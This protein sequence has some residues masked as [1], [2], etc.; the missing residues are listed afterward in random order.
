MA[1]LA[2]SLPFENMAASNDKRE[3]GRDGRRKKASREAPPSTSGG[4]TRWISSPVL[5]AASVFAVAVLLYANT[6]GHDFVWDDRDLIVENPAVR[7]LDANT[8]EKIFTEDFWRASRLGGGYYRPL[9]TLSYHVQYKLFDG[10]PAGF[11]VANV[12][13]NALTCALVFAFV[14]LLFGNVPFGL[15][16]GLLFAVHPI[17]TENVAWIAGRTDV[18]STLWAMASLVFY[19]LAR[20]RNIWW[21]APASATFALSLLAKESSAF[22]PLLILLL[23]LGPF[24][25]FFARKK[26]VWL[27]PVLYAAVLVAYLLQRRDVIGQFGST[28]DAYAPG[29]LGTV[30]LPL[31]ILAGYAFKLVF[32]FKLSG[33][34]DAPVPESLADP[35]AAAGLLV[36]AAI[37]LGAI[38]F[39]RRPDVV[40]GAGVFLLGLGPVSNI[41]PI[42]EISAERFLYFPSLGFALVLGGLFSSALIA[43][44]PGWRAAAGDGYVSWPGMKPSVAG[45]LAAVFV[46]VLV[47]F[48]ARTVTR[49][50]DWKSE[51]ILFAKTAAAAPQSARAFLNVGNVARRQG[52]LSDAA[53]AYTRA[54]QISPDYPDALSNLAWVYASEGRIDDALP[55]VKR[56]LEKA[57]NDVSLLN[58]LGSIYFQKKRFED[59]ALYFERSIQHDPD[60]AIANYNLGLIRMQQGDRDAARKHFSRAAGK[61]PRFVR[62]YYYLAVIESER[63]N[64]AEAKRLALEFLGQYDREDSYRQRARSIASGK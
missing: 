8:V 54:L 43:K 41:I 45:K 58:N 7:V 23:E 44:Y 9:V 25:R 62:A 55:L 34:Y 51:E 10:D 32:P 29:L 24:D 12:L 11:H 4:G 2:K 14:F 19:V 21:L 46:L 18:L 20:K 53:E 38:K 27:A 13:W 50:N 48:A 63:G 52:R 22:L 47:A 28:Y 31:S 49:N 30:A 26:R 60:Q 56:A 35:H 16:T 61:G 57:P 36:L 17:H 64:A 33:E 39:R 42:G 6:I 15:A 1:Q 40:L 5:A 37:V 59:A 3:T